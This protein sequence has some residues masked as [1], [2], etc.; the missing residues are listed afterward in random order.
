VEMDPRLGV[1]ELKDHML[2][3]EM[4]GEAV[5]A[6]LGVSEAMS[7]AEV[8]R[9]VKGGNFSVVASDTVPMG[10]T[11]RPLNFLTVEER[12]LGRL[13]QL[14]HQISPFVLQMCR[15][16]GPG[17]RDTDQLPPSW[18]RRCWL[19]ARSA[20][21]SRTP[22]TFVCVC[23]TEFLSLY[24]MEQLTQE[25]AKCTMDTHDIIVTALL[26]HLEE[27]CRTRGPLQ[28]AGQVPGPDEGPARRLPHREAAAVTPR[29]AGGDKVNTFSTLLLEPYTPPRAQ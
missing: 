1:A 19:S 17:G 13:M 20:S 9:L 5:S 6:F 29:G 28:D 21:S 7:D 3:A 8:G 26:P 25:L 16:L 22:T 4:M 27:P 15:V 18:R 10:H 23:V 12:G 14:K 11:L 2:R 24:K